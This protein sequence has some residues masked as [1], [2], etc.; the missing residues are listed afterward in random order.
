MGSAQSPGVPRM[1]TG[2]RASASIGVRSGRLRA[3]EA[4]GS[5]ANRADGTAEPGSGPVAAAAPLDFADA[6]PADTSDTRLPCPISDTRHAAPLRRVAPARLR[7]GQC[8]R[9]ADPRRP[10]AA[11]VGDSPARPRP[12][13]RGA[14]RRLPDHPRYRESRD[15]RHRRP[16]RRPTSA[17]PR[18]VPPRPVPPRRRTA[19]PELAQQKPSI[20]RNRT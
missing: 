8:A 20:E 12:G 17:P 11:R 16:R 14:D 6:A 1:D 5:P 4:A 2:R 18:P 13:R 10:R 15:H 9:S 3:D 7:R 19:R